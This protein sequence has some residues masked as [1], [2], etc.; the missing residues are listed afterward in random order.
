MKQENKLAIFI[1]CHENP[2]DVKTYKALRRYGYTRDDYFIVLDDED[3]TIEEYV[4][5]FGKEHVVTFS[6]D[7]IAKEFDEMDNNG[8]RSCVVYARNACFKLAKQLGYTYFIE[9]DDDYI[10]FQFRYIDNGKLRLVYPN[11]LDKVF[12]CVLDYY[13]NTPSIKSLA[14]AQCGDLIGGSDAYNRKFLRKAMNSFI[15]STERPFKF[16]GRINEDVNTYCLE[17]SRGNLFCTIMDLIIN[18]TDTQT[19]NK[20][21]MTSI[22]SDTGTYRKSFYSV[23]CCPSFV[24]ISMM[25]QNYFRIHHNIKWNNAVPKIISSRFK[26]ER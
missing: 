3:T 18:Q 24:K 1:L 25:G 23:M 22:Y 21:G 16:N 6:K 5:N 4:K 9:L 2:N 14:F 20:N 19:N 7:E 8:N 10:E 13:I 11:N 12:D 15:C 26:K 17:G